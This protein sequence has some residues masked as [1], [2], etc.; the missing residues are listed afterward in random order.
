MQYRIDKKFLLD[1]L[2]IWDSFLKRK[3]HL[4]ACGGTAMTL[5]DIKNSTKDVDLLVPD[6]LE[7]EYLIKILQ[8]LG[9]KPISG[10]G[11]KRGNEFVFELFR[12]NKVHTTEL[13]ESPLKRE[14]HIF[15]REFNYIYLGA[16]NYYDLIISKLFRFSAVD[17]Q[18]C[19]CL[20]K[21]KK[22]KIDINKL[23]KRFQ[24]TAS[25][26]V[27]EEKLYI[28]LSFFLILLKKEGLIDKT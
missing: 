12:G 28:N 10:W 11:W 25:F 23:E 13:L 27:S 4:I 17:I 7:Y 20:I 21:D 1:R 19:L 6:L 18:D 8:Q 5:L 16:L 9:Y 14:N 2:S 3:V 26:D 15:I 22:E 24:N